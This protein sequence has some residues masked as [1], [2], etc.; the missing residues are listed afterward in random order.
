MEAKGAILEKTYLTSVPTAV[1]WDRCAQ[2]EAPATRQAGT[3]EDDED[4]LW[5]NMEH[6]S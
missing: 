2:S 5:E 3:D 1:V 4:E 6:I